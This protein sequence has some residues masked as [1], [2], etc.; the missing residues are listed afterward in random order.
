MSPTPDDP[1]DACVE[2]LISARG[3]PDVAAALLGMV[4]RAGCEGMAVYRL[5]PAR[6]LLLSLGGLP[7][8]GPATLSK[9]DSPAW[10]AVATGEPAADGPLT[11]WPLRGVDPGD[12][13]GVVLL[14]GE[15]GPALPRLLALAGRALRRVAETDPARF[16]AAM[17]AELLPLLDEGVIFVTTDGEL[18]HFAPALERISGW[19]REDVATTGWTNLVYDSD[20]ERRAAQAA[21]A[22]LVLGKPSEGA[23][24]S[25]V[26]KDGE[27]FT[28]GIWT[29]LVAD[30]A[31]GAP[32]VLGVFRD[33][34]REEAA[35]VEA[36]RADGLAELGRVT[37]WV[38]HDVNNLLCAVGGHAELIDAWTADP[39]VRRSAQ[40]IRDSVRR[41]SG[42]TRRLLASG[43]GSETSRTTVRVGEVVRE[44]CELYEATAP[45]GVR[46]ELA[47]EADPVVE[48]DATQ[49]HQ[50]V[51]NLLTNAGQ[52][53]SA[54]GTIRVSVGA[55][56][57][58][59]ASTWR[60]PTAP[61]AGEAVARVVVHDSGPGFPV[62][63]PER[64]FEP[65]FTTRRGGHGVGLAAVRTVVGAHHGALS[66]SNDG[67]A[68]IE[69]YFPLSNRPETVLEDLL[70][71]HGAPIGRRV[72]IL[73]NEPQI[74]EFS[75]VA[76]TARGLEVRDF[77]TSA[78]LLLQAARTPRGEGP[79]VLVVDDP[80]GEGG[81]AVGRLRALGIAAPVVWISSDP[82]AL[83][84][85]LAREGPLLP[86]PFTGGTLADLVTGLVGRPDGPA[87]R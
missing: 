60:A 70:R 21:I 56:T 71:A 38:A 82:R 13:V 57:L 72:W 75:R 48:A 74:L 20:E 15:V 85:R 41:G 11:A 62:L 34:T 52:A 40:T 35:R 25:L 65:F 87:P 4:G 55:A 17:L 22:A 80:Y 9:G 29:R 6:G 16:D 33:V 36:V 8:P 84:E 49:L 14:Q 81:A 7:E 83:P 3:A 61:A 50:A 10:R 66:L 26:R 28:A 58:P 44:A 47:I 30:P 43:G 24:R 12:I 5:D 67:G 54:G 1:S 51:L 37:R 68:R 73:D 27:R 69:L 39:R 77:A 46:V 45:H 76:L 86:K 31:G 78:A 59:E 42:M 19:T 2:A 53:C 79:D 23:R 64:L 18:R 63:D 32:G